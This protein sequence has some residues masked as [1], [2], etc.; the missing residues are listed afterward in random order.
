[1]GYNTTVVILNDALGSLEEDDGFGK[2]LAA[3]IRA[4]QSSRPRDVSIGG[5]VNACHVVETHHADQMVPIM[6]GSNYGWPIEGTYVSWRGSNEEIE[7][8]LL[9]QLAKKHGY[10]LRRLKK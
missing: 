10:G 1:M 8:E 4:L 5:H 2:R 7:L 6:V 3:G 9:Q